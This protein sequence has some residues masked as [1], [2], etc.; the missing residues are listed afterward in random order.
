[1]ATV[2]LDTVMMA[3][4]KFELSSL[5]R[6][7]KNGLPDALPFVP[8]LDGSFVTGEPYQGYVAGM[9]AK[10]YIFGMNLDEGAL[11]AAGARD[12]AGV[13]LNFATYAILLDSVF[14]SAN[15]R[16]IESVP[17]YRARLFG[18]TAKQALSNLI[19]DFAFDCGNLASADSAYAVNQDTTPA[20]PIYGYRFEQ[21]PFFAMWDTISAC[22]PGVA[23][24]V[25]HGVEIPYVF[26]TFAYA[27]SVTVA[28]SIPSGSGY[29]VPKPTAADSALAVR[30]GKA[31]TNFAKGRQPLGTSWA[32]YTGGSGA[33]LY[34]FGGPGDGQALTTLS[35][36]ANC[37]QLW[38]GIPPLGGTIR[39]TAAR[40][41]APPATSARIG[42]RE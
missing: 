17:A 40:T 4:A 10:P 29:L 27:D 3:Q 30:M 39:A 37:R 35:T 7:L 13:L 18:Q 1:L 26:N 19:T 5:G 2:S 25:C 14:G 15:R 12:K 11:F 8:V 33:T 16:T 6:L 34:R 28:D 24:N 20:P 38:N 23:G 21:P 9:P 41:E 31:W 42:L 36:A 32:P 22:L